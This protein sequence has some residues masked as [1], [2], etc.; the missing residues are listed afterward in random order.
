MRTHNHL[1]VKEYCHSLIPKILE[2]N[3]LE[4]SENI[5]MD[6]LGWVNPVFF[7]NSKYV[8]RFNA[9]DINLPKIQREN[10]AYQLMKE[11]GIP[12]PEYVL[13]DVSK[14]ISK[15]DYMITKIISGHNIE[16]SWNS[17]SKSQRYSLSHQAGQLLKKIHTI[18]NNFFGDLVTN[19][20]MSQSSQWSEYL[21]CKLTFH[22]N[23]A[24]EYKLFDAVLLKNIWSIFDFFVPIIDDQLRPSFVH[25]DFHFGNMLFEK[26]LIKSILDFEWSFWGD[27]LY[28]LC[29][30][31]DLDDTWPE[32]QLAFKDGYGIAGFDK[33]EKLKMNFYQ[34]IKNIEL[35][36]VAKNIFQNLK[37]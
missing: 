14:S 28:D 5:L 23:E 19:S 32:S 36:V 26:D 34:M 3:G 21:K 10:R 1:I 35:S 33:S 15:Y 37:F 29:R 4:K 16:H 20:P 12:V 2:L 9:R 7:V 31:E 17:L 13:C 22:L 30:V 18:K 11:N 8:I 25:V 27:P 24:S 6:Q